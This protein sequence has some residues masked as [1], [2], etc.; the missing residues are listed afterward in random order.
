[1]CINFV[2]VSLE[3]VHE[4]YDSDKISL[5]FLITNETLLF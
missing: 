1:M 3:F 2:I 4:K 5:F